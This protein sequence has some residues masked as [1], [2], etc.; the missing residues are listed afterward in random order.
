MSA[1]ILIVAGE[2]SG[3]KYGAALVRAYR[4]LHPGAR[5]FGVGGPALAAEGL[6]VL[7][8]LRELAVMGLVEVVSRIP[9]LRKILADVAAA[10]RERRPAAAVLIDSPDFNLRLAKKLRAAGIPV[11]YYVS[12][13]VWAWRRGR[14]RTIA[15]SVRK[16]L[17]IYPFEAGLYA[18]RGIPHAYVGHPLEDKVKATRGRAEVLASLG[19]D[20][21]RPFVA[22]MPGSREGEL[23]RH[24][25]V[26]VPAILRL[27]R[28][29]GAQ[30]AMIKAESL[31]DETLERLLPKAGRA[32]AIVREGAYDVM[33]AADLVLAACGTAN[34][35]AAFLGAPLITFYKISP[36]TYAV[37]KPFVRIRRYS[38]VNILAGRDVVPELIQGRLT[39]D[40]LFAEAKRLLDSEGERARMRKDMAEVKALMEVRDP[41][42]NAARELDALVRGAA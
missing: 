9:R 39:A 26:I 16:M 6:D 13:T 42:G 23:S 2:N 22:V 31:S 24:L 11:L 36:L 15:A 21:A 28:E 8:P 17:L 4:K 3:D 12:P 10:A 25:S 1:P 32:L 33:A 18:A 30:V 35:E 29:V 41:S 40:R 27:Q 34:L 37:G 38:I 7:H 19:L 20:P 5:F 14:L